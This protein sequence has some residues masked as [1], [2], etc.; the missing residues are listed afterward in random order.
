M[1]IIELN[2]LLEDNARLQVDCGV[3]NA[4]L[5]VL[6]DVE[7]HMKS[8]V[9]TDEVEVEAI[10]MPKSNLIE[11]MDEVLEIGQ[12]IWHSI[13]KRMLVIMQ[14]PYQMFQLK[15]QLES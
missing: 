15:D 14:K 2:V 10:L 8:S 9:D 4:R 1:F 5:K 7:R 13:Q 6:E 12:K 3:L 11:L